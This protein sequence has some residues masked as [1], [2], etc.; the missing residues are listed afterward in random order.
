MALEVNDANNRNNFVRNTD[1]ECCSDDD[2]KRCCACKIM[3]IEAVNV[4]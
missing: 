4:S 1:N 3:A 2:A